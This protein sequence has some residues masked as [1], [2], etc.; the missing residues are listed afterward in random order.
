MKNIIIDGID[1]AGKTTLANKIKYVMRDFGGCDIKSLGHIDCQSQF[2]RYIREY[3]VNQNTIFD[4]GHLSEVV[5][6]EYLRDNLSISDPQLEILNFLVSSQ[7][8]VVLAI[9]SYENFC[10]RMEE[11]ALRYSKLIGIDAF[12]HLNEQFIKASD[13]LN[14]IIYTSDSFEYLDNF[15]NQIIS[16]CK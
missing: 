7:F 13:L 4:R 8:I 14:P 6:S 5:Y 1:R 16:L 12:D 15:T 3:S 9:P 10:K 11:Y 2:M